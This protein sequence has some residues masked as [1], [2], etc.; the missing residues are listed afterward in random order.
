M[1]K[2]AQAKDEEALTI[3]DAKQNV[4]RAR[5]ALALAEAREEEAMALQKLHEAKNKVERAMSS[6]AAFHSRQEVLKDCLKTPQAV[7]LVA[8]F[9][10]RDYT[11]EEQSVYLYDVHRTAQLHHKTARVVQPLDFYTHDNE[12]ERSAI[13]RVSVPRR[14]SIKTRT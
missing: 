4:K 11:P 12:S 3:S 8:K 2:N 9:A 6:A 10:P 1:N 13:I 5:A 14:S 7:D